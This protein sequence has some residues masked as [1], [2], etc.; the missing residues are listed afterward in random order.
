MCIRDRVKKG[1]TSA[2]IGRGLKEQGVIKSVDAF[3]EAANADPESL[4]IQVGFYPLKKQMKASAALDVLTD[5]TSMVQ[6]VVTVPEGARVRD[7]VKTIVAKTDLKRPAVLAALADPDAIGLPAIANGNPEG[8]LYP[9]TYSVRPKMTAQEL[10]SEM[11]AKTVAVEKQLDI[12][13]RAKAIGRTP[14]EILTL[15]SIIEYEANRDEDYPKVARVFYN[16]LDKGMA[17]QSDATV[18]YASGREGDVWTTAAER[19]SDNAY[20]TYKHPGLPPGPIGSPGQ[21]TIEA[22]LHPAK[23]NWLYFVPDFEKGTT[24]FTS[25]YAEHVRNANKAKEFCRTSEKC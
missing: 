2:A 21:K 4:N 6:D 5:P 17:L 23:G 8:Y 20:N 18:S 7:I 15:A 19:N 24:L 10:I 22:A 12:V 9:A 14:A 11:V 1:D 16:R 13:A 3:M 25:S